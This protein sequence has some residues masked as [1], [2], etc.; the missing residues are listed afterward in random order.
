MDY[1][2]KEPCKANT[3]DTNSDQCLQGF[4]NFFFPVE[5]IPKSSKM[6]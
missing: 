1:P 3:E 6:C 2:C 5:H 4:Y